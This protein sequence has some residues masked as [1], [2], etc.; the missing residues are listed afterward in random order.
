MTMANTKMHITV[1]QHGQFRGY[2]KSVSYSKG[3]FVITANINEA[4]GYASEWVIQQEID[5]LTVMGYDYGYI[6]G[7]D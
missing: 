3:K 5:R 2:V 1:I 7:Y 6:F 4:K